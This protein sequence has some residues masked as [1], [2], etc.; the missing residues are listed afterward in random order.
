MDDPFMPSP[1]F[2]L[3][4]G[5]PQFIGTLTRA[6]SAL[7]GISL[8]IEP[9]GAMGSR[10]VGIPLGSVFPN[11]SDLVLIKMTSD[12]Q[13][14]LKYN[15]NNFSVPYSIDLPFEK[16]NLKGFYTFIDRLNPIEYFFY[17]NILL[18]PW[19]PSRGIF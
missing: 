6:P 8:E 18:K 5:R 13:Y 1:L 16:M 7:R 14:V 4:A 15:P 12:Q 10:V 17:P 11:L 9:M 19:R 3:C 2:L